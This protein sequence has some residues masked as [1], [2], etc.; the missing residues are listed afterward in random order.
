MIEIVSYE[1]PKCYERIILE[2]Y[3]KFFGYLNGKR[4]LLPKK[5]NFTLNP[6]KQT[7]SS[8]LEENFNDAIA[9]LKSIEQDNIEFVCLDDED[10]NIIAL[11]RI[12]KEDN[13]LHIT[14][15]IYL[16]YPNAVEKK[17]MLTE[18]TIAIE[19]YAFSFNLQMV[20]YEIP[21]FDSIGLEVA[22]EFGYK[23]IDESSRETIKY[24]TFLLEKEIPKLGKENEWTR[25]RKQRK[26]QN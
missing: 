26:E 17:Q 6:N 12:A 8:L 19:H 7:P 20:L 9:A 10:A 16:N 3:Y 11:A 24:N 25:S 23:F 5:I 18:L 1:L 2:E 21:K 22:K 14:D 13:S 15:V 4:T